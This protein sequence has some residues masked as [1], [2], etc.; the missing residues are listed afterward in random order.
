MPGC[1]AAPLALAIQKCQAV[2]LVD[3]KVGNC[4]VK[5][6]G[7]TWLDWGFF[8]DRTPISAVAVQIC[9][10]DNIELLEQGRCFCKIPPCTD[11]WLASSTR[12]ISPSKG[13]H[14]PKKCAQWTLLT[15][16]LLEI[17]IY[18]VSF[19]AVKVVNTIH[20]PNIILFIY[21]D[22]QCIPDP[23][24]QPMLPALVRFWE[25]DQSW[26]V[27]GSVWLGDLVVWFI[28]LRFSMV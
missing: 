24:H 17:A 5:A 9:A 4:L 6:L 21:N 27:S 2:V 8:S 13:S 16:V 3:S 14:V 7:L 26:L 22:I 12:R 11:D 25:N 1:H 18:S 10:S 20:N 23:R 19:P 28:A 15:A